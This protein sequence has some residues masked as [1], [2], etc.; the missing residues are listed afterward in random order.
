AVAVDGG[1]GDGGRTIG[2]EPAR[3]K[4]RLIVADIATGQG[5]GRVIEVEA[6]AADG[7]KITDHVDVG[8]RRG[9]DR[10]REAA[11]VAAASVAVYGAVADH[12]RG[13]TDE[14]AAF[15]RGG[16]VVIES[17][18]GDRATAAG[19]RGEHDHPAFV[20]L[21]SVAID[22]GVGEGQLSAGES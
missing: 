1:V 21:G 22:V 5:Q 12:E 14:G 18:A 13:A 15:A 9:G 8:K 10:C 7:G 2:E 6:A 20:A 4:T 3:R 16:A 17:A 11:V 19:F